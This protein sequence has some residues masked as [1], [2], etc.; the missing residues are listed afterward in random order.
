MKKIHCI[1]AALLAGIL[2]L[3]TG[4]GRSEAS[5]APAEIVPAAQTAA[6][7]LPD[8]S[9]NSLRQTMTGTPQVFAAAYFGYHETQD[10]QIP[11][12]PFA[13]MEENAPELC[14]EFPFLLEIPEDRIIG[15]TGD[16]FCIVPLD[17]D[18]TVAVS[19]G[20]WDEENRQY[21]YDDILY[22]SNTGGPILLFCNNAGWEP[23]TQVYLSGQSGEVF[24]YPREDDN[25][26]VSPA[27]NHNRED[28]ICD[29]SPYRELLTKRYREMKGEWVM[30]TK[31]FLTGTTWSWFG[32]LKDGRDVSY[33][34][35]FD[36]DT[37]SIRWNDGIDK[38]DHEYL[39]APWELTCDEDF[40]VLSVDFREFA[41]VL[42][43]DLL[44]HE[45]FEEL[46]VAM[47]VVQEEMP[48]GGEP[49]YRFLMQPI[50]PEPT[51]MIGTWE[52]AWTEVEGDCN[53]A[54][55]G[56]GTIEIRSAASAGLLMSYTSRDFPGSDFYDELLTVDM[57]Q[58]YP[59][60]GND[61]W[62]ADVDYTGP[63]D[64]TY[65]V[66]LTANGTLIKQNCFLTD[67]APMVSYEYFRPVEEYLATVDGN[68]EDPYAYAISQDGRVPELSELMDTF[69][70]SWSGYAL[71]LMD[72][73]VPGD[74]AGLVNLYD[75]G[76]YGEYIENASGSWYYE[77]GKLHLT[78]VPVNDS[79]CFVD[80][81]F[82]VLML[83]EELL[84]GRTANG[85][86]LPH[87]YSDMLMDTL[88][89][90]KG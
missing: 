60:C 10:S 56:E 40:A 16:L 70:L 55:P 54:E 77:N 61:A 81:S 7:M 68:M 87:F 43:Y 76:E 45:D 63:W 4:C 82:P 26:C 79:G 80:D 20:Y 62:V 88:E 57:G 21:I 72:D 75:V 47:D 51:E 78:L 35:T 3:T 24:W 6:S 48:I 33:E 84:I 65:A 12:D 5:P 23:D 17:E 71:E 89:Q 18:A 37:L 30:P 27:Q 22:S 11:V 53:E 90:P 86:G 32:F 1:T 39:H 19:K 44:Y 73:H 66:T 29:F 38:M 28:L 46:Y 36:A 25:R 2:L 15:E 42:R 52:L 59:L 67:G 14:Q 31:E 64:T 74:K 9:L 13:V 85:T 83:G 41:G 58:M 8:A 34:V 50:T 49:L 69:W